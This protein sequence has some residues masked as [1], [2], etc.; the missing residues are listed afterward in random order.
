MVKFEE[1]EAV[2]FIDD[3]AGW[4]RPVGIGTKTELVPVILDD[5]G[6]GTVMLGAG[7]GR[8]GMPTALVNTSPD[9]LIPV[10]RE[11]VRLMLDLSDIEVT[12]E[13]V[14]GDEK[15]TPVPT[16]IVRESLAEGKGVTADDWMPEPLD[17]IVN[18][19]D[20]EIV[21]FVKGVAPVP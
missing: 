7:D 16:G 13:D 9:E 2:A 6:R 12:P 11:V 10:P 1:N 8:K 19:M 3:C 17:A 14:I 18:D 21:E 20:P 4:L 15:E 5:P